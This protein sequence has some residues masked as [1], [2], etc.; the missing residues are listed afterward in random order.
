MYKINKGLAPP[1]LL[2][3]FKEKDHKYNTRCKS[4]CY[5]VD[6]YKAAGQSTLK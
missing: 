4:D 5:K 1:Y 2:E 6:S 3:L